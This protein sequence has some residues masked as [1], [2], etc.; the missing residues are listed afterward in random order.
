M[1]YLET[2]VVYVLKIA[3]QGLH[4]IIPGERLIVEPDDFSS[5]N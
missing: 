2:F 4:S 3:H 5:F 1:S